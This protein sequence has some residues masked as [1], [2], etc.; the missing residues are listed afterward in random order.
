MHAVMTA[1]HKLARSAAFF[2]TTYYYL[3]P[4]WF[5]MNAAAAG[6]TVAA[7]EGE[8]HEGSLRLSCAEA[9]W[10]IY[11]SPT[12]SLAL[13]PRFSPGMTPFLFSLSVSR[14]STPSVP[15]QSP[16]GPPCCCSH[17][18][19]H[20]AAAGISVSEPLDHEPSGTVWHRV[21]RK[22][23]GQWLNCCWV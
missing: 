6:G 10:S 9:G 12:F 2:T 15:A 7:F 20:S 18:Q 4:R 3:D 1:P 8:E 13:L 16:F 14:C 19:Q 21:G 5:M 17:E 22:V 11:P 23:S